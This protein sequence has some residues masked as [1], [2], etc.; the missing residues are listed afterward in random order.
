LLFR[1][2]LKTGTFV[3]TF[4]LIGAAIASFGDRF[5]FDGE[6][7]ALIFAGIVTAIYFFVKPRT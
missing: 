2:N 6:I 3:V 7:A 5:G 4:S 1:K